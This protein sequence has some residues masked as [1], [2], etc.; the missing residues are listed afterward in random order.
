MGIIISADTKYPE[1]VVR[2][3]DY[4]Y[5]EEMVELMNWGIEGETFTV[6]AEGNHAFTDTIM[7]AED[8]VQAA[9]DFGITSSSACRTGIPFTPITFEAMTEQI[10]LESWWSPDAGY[11]DSQYWIE[12]GKIGGVESVSPFDRPP[13]LTLADNEATAKAELTTNC[14]TYAKENALKFITGEWDV[15]DDAQWDT[16][17]KGV[18]S[19]VSDFDGT[20]SLLLEKSDLS[21]INQ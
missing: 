20:L 3:I 2:M 18:K 16:Y 10:P 13:V 6:D 12:S 21:S 17:I 19:Q 8:P 9:A 11:F 7:K 4:Q 1:W 15:A 5:S 14:E